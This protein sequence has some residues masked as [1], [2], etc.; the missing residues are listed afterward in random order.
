MT[1]QRPYEKVNRDNIDQPIYWCN[2]HG[3]YFSSNCSECMLL[4]NDPET[5]EK[6]QQVII[7]KIKSLKNDLENEWNNNMENL[8]PEDYADLKASL[9]ILTKLINGIEER[10]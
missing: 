9:R 7:A 5:I 2:K 1:E 4:E 3:E 6:A 10:N 8:D